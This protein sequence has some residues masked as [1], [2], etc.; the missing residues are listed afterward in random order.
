MDKNLVL[1][2]RPHRGSFE[3]SMK[4]KVEFTNRGELAYIIKGIYG[5]K[6]KPFDLKIELYG[7]DP[8]LPEGGVTHIVTGRKTPDQTQFVMGFIHIESK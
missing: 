5:Y 4:E 6:C 3:D 8:R 2:F 7:I 1:V